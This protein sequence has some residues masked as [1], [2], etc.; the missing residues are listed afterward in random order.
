MDDIVD[1]LLK[2]FIF[3]DI[4]DDE[5]RDAREIIREALREYGERRYEDGFGDGYDTR[6]REMAA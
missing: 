1:Q 2:K 5:E 6:G 3:L 4:L